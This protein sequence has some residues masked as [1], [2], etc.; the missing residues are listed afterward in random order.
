M[1][2]YCFGEEQSRIISLVFKQYRYLLYFCFYVE[3]DSFFGAFDLPDDFG[4]SSNVGA[5][6]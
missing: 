5:T 3:K 2:I 6:S 4:S 1:Q